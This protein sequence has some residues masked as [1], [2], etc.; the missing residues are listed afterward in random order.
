MDQ[1]LI[2][3]YSDEWKQIG[4]YRSPWGVDARE[5]MRNYVITERENFEYCHFKVQR[6]PSL[7]L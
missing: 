6:H 2:D 4:E 7:T 3:K 5:P 1:A